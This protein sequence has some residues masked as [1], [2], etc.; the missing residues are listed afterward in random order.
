MAPAVQFTALQP[1]ALVPDKHRVER[2]A[3]RA[4]R[5]A[6]AENFRYLRIPRLPAD[7]PPWVLGQELGW[8][9]RSPVTVPMSPL[10]DLGVAL[11]SAEDAPRTGRLLGREGLWQRGPDWIAT[12]QAEWLHLGDYRTPAGWEGMFVPNGQGTVEW[13]LGWSAHLP[14]HTFLMV[15]PLD[16][17]GL[18]IPLGVISAKS[19]NAMRTRGGMSIAVAPRR[20]LTV[21]RGQP[22]ARLVL[23]HADTLRATATTAADDPHPESR[24][25][26]EAE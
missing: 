2:A 16:V 24:P 20:P 18:D 21:T 13:R 25:G 19:V 17:D 22:V 8:Q 11:A 7:C 1:W 3:A 14:E 10:N 5:D 15:M 23:L 4:E 26:Q 9:V 12:K 6:Y